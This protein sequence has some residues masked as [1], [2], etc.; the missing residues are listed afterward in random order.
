MSALRPTR[1][2]PGGTVT[3]KPVSPGRARYRPLTPSRREGRVAPVEP[4]VTNSCAFLIAHEAAGAASIRLSLRPPHLEGLA[5]AQLGRVSAAG[6]DNAR[7]FTRTARPNG[8]SQLTVGSA[9][10]KERDGAQTSL[11]EEFMRQS[12]RFWI[13]SFS[14]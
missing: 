11:P 8:T 6:C 10:L 2:E 5:H 7:A 14:D 3:Q 9:M 12:G 4:V 1:R 13:V